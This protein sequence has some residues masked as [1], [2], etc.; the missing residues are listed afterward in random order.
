M[1]VNV[2]VAVVNG[3]LRGV[4]EGVVGAGDLGEAVG[5]AGVVAVAVWVVLE[6]EGVEFP[7]NWFS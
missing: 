1:H 3:T 2:V 6:G 7:G 4:A 5:G